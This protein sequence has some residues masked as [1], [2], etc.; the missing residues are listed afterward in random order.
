[1]SEINIDTNVISSNKTWKE[2]SDR[3]NITN[4]QGTDKQNGLNATKKVRDDNKTAKS[5]QI[6]STSLNAAVTVSPG[7]KNTE[8]GTYSDVMDAVTESME[9][10]DEETKDASMSDSTDKMSEEDY[11]D[12]EEEGVSLESYEAG[13]LER[14]LLRMKENREFRSD[15][16]ED[17]IQSKE[18]MEETIKKIAVG[19]KISDPMAKKL[20]MKLVDANLPVTVE[21]VSALLNASGMMGAVGQLSEGGKAYLIDNELT[22]TVENIYQSQYSGS[23]IKSNDSGFE[24]IRSQVEAI[25]KKAGMEVSDETMAQAKW[26]YSNELPITKD[27][28]NALASINDITENADDDYILQK[29]TEAMAKGEKPE[30]ANLDNSQEKAVEQAKDTYSALYDSLEGSIDIEAITARRQLEEIRLKLTSEAGLKLLSKGIALDTTDLQNVVEGLKQI[31]REYYH[32][33]FKEA[34]VDPTSEQVTML[35]NTL[36]TVDSLKQSPSYVIG[37]TLKQ[38]D[39]MTLG[40]LHEAASSMK[41]QMAK[42]GELYEALMTKPRAD[43]GDSIKKAFQNIPDILNDLHMEDTQDNER[44]VRIL[45]YNQMDINK[46]SI[47]AVKAYD[48]KVNSLLDGLKPA[49]TVELIKRDI[50]PLDVHMDNLNQELRSIDNDMGVTAEEKYSKFLWKLEHTEGISEEERSSYIGIYRLLNNV[51]KSDGAVIGT[52]LN[53]GMDLTLSNLLTAMRSRKAAGMDYEINDSFGLLSEVKFN[54]ARISDQIEAGFDE[55][56]QE[57]SS[58][59]NA[60]GSQSSKEQIE[61]FQNVVSKIMDE[62]SPEKL[63]QIASEGLD[64]IMDM[65]LEKLEDNL[66]QAVENNRADK[67]YARYNT[68]KLREVA[69]TSDEATQFLDHFEVEPTIKNI[70]SVENFYANGKSFFKDFNKYADKEYNDIIFDFTDSIEDAATL[71]EKY[72]QVEAKVNQLIEKEYE[73]PAVDES[74]KRVEELRIYSNGIAL[75]KRLSNQECY[76]IPIQTDGDQITTISL[77]LRKGNLNTGKVQVSMDSE[78]Y[79]K[80]DG[81]FT[82]KNAMINGFILCD[83]RNGFR[84]MNAATGQMTQDFENLGLKV[85]QVNVGFDDVVFE[86]NLGLDS[87]KNISP[88]TRQ[89]YQVAKIA[90]KTISKVILKK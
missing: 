79:G 24:E 69:Q 19:C 76:Q 26:L 61:Y 88:S 29:M 89:L 81:E 22:P 45:S 9:T 36:E 39:I 6:S 49:V 34:S 18:E 80:L 75:A 30:A 38:R 59:Q 62:V 10:K 83:S 70:V 1:M 74:S 17:Q 54:N 44:A 5:T 37:A 53:N 50:N 13:R 7:E 77:T 12:L 51:E 52:V 23:M 15:H 63:E 90:V 40:T 21:N 47:N 27:S 41:V 11:Q 3:M 25:I 87:T 48:T 60:S 43:L 46:E 58:G 67:E 8:T 33:M 2:M 31:E 64:G 57:Y 55:D 85:Q 84:A 72:D 32:G 35:Q 20:A 4:L 68:E 65:T 78:A 14:A 16:L 42:A 28:L 73:K 82:V 66:E 86:Q 71:Q 56:G